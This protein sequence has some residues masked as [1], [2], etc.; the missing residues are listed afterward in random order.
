MAMMG[1]AAE[2]PDAYIAALS[3]WQRERCEMM[4]AAIRR[5]APFEETI[6]WTNLVFMANGPC[7]LI[8]AEEHRVLLGFWRGKRLRDLD[9]RIKASGKYELGN[10]VMTEATEVTADAVSRLAADAFRLNT[11]L[12]NPAART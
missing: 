5:A 11:E 10:L 7:I 8:R 3:G 6:K 1:P 12:G 4:R 2:N 9:P